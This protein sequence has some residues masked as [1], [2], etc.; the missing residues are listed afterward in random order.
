M[1]H[2]SPLNKVP[3]IFLRSS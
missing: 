3:I 2:E 1:S